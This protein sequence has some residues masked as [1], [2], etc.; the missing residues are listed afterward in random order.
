MVWNTSSFQLLI[1][2][3]GGGFTGLF[4][5]SPIPGAGNL[6][7]SIAAQA[8]T[9]PY[10]NPYKAGIASYGA[11]GAFSLL[12]AGVL[13]LGAAFMATPSVFNVGGVLGTNAAL[14]IT[15]GAGTE[16][17]AT[18]SALTLGDSGTG[19][20][21]SVQSGSD[22]TVYQLGEN[23]MLTTAA[24][25]ITSTSN[26]GVTGLSQHVAAGGTYVF[27][28]IYRV[29]QGVANTGQLL[30]FTGPAASQVVW[31]FW[32]A[33][34]GGSLVMIAP[35]VYGVLASEPITFGAANAEAYNFFTGFA[36][37]TAGG[38]FQGAAAVGTPGNSFTIQPGCIMKVRRVS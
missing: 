24:Q 23:V 9:D 11:G 26:T 17:G 28:G 38:T 32:G 31:Y 19:L 15:S 35:S 27:E 37:F 3:A 10:G 12:Q 20:Q 5:Y 6:I 30:G 13:E 22:G 4:V 8:G 29:K 33:A 7:A 18:P 36:T 14:G 2:S 25:T 34:P 21:A 16:G 1:I